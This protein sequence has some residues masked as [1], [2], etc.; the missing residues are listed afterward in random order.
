MKY[1]I[2]LAEVDTGI[3][4][5]EDGSRALGPNSSTIKF[6]SIEQ[7]RTQAEALLEKLP[8]AEAWIGSETDSKM[9]HFISL[10]YPAYS[11]EKRAFEF[12][13]CL[14]LWRR[15]FTPRP[16]CKYYSATSLSQ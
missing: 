2:T 4:L 11:R 15:W 9:E 1:F 5:C 6:E 10:D 7:A 12:W 16:S 14:P 8:Y 3:V 13:F